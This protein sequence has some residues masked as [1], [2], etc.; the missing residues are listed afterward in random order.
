MACH[1]LSGL[2]P[3]KILFLHVLE[4]EMHKQGVTFTVLLL[5]QR[6]LLCLSQLLVAT[7]FPW[8]TAL[9]LQSPPLSLHRL[10]LCVTSSSASLSQ[11]YM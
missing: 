1:V 4:P 3:Q 7:S 2:K 11:G 8:L 6:L 10:L 9:S 5:Q